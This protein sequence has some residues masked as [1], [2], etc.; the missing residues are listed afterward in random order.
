MEVGVATGMLGQMVA[1]HE[2]FLTER[3]A[4]LLFSS[5][6]AVMAGQF[7]RAGKLLVAF[8]PAAFK[9]PLTCRKQTWHD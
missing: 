6:S 1:A 3:A 2:A 4:E 9:R 7:I 5:V 8:L